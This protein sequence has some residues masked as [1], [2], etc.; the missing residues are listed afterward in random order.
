MIKVSKSYGIKLSMLC[1][2]KRVSVHTKVVGLRI[3]IDYFLYPANN[4]NR[5]QR[6]G[7]GATQRAG[8]DATQQLGTRRPNRWV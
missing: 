1:G 6:M 5:T 2:Q 4:Y 3:L 8:Y 7:R